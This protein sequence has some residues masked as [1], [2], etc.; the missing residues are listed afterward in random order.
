MGSAWVE[1]GGGRSIPSANPDNVAAGGATD[2]RCGGEGGEEGWRGID[3][4]SYCSNPCSSFSSSFFPLCVRRGFD[5]KILR[6]A[7]QYTNKQEYRML[8]T[9]NKVTAMIFSMFY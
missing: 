6:S 2:A 4:S 8:G 3:N 5:E 1:R 9:R 7:V